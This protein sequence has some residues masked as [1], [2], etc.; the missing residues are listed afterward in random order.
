[1]TEQDALTKILQL[2][3]ASY[4]AL[5]EVSGPHRSAL[6]DQEASFGE[7][8]GGE[9]EASETPMRSM[10]TIDAPRSYRCAQ[11]V[12]QR[13]R[14]R[15][16]EI[17]DAVAARRELID[18]LISPDPML[19]ERLAT[20]DHDQEVRRSVASAL[21]LVDELSRSVHR[22]A[23]EKRDAPLTATAT[24]AVPRT[25]SVQQSTPREESDI[26]EC[27]MELSELRGAVDHFLQANAV[28]MTEL[29]EAVATITEAIEGESAASPDPGVWTTFL[30]AIE[31]DPDYRP[32]SPKR[33]VS[34]HTTIEELA[35]IIYR[36]I[37]ANRAEVVELQSRLSS[38]AGR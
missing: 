22:M 38:A 4:G 16:T 30:L 2:R 23:E 27:S 1:V 35:C 19:T 5:A 25:P 36:C 7:L 21:G 14:E 13:A 31:T 3:A 29:T 32:S 26:P 9:D 28:M 34:M 18:Q 6:P 12:L 11:D 24:A 10:Y 15:S 17:I 37:D 20:I 8:L 33:T